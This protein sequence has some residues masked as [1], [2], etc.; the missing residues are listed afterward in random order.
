MKATS[1]N[2]QPING[3][4]E[5]HN[6]RTKELKYV[7]KD[8]SDKNE[9]F[10]IDTVKDRLATIKRT[11][12]ESTG[13]K[14]QKKATPIREGVVVIDKNTSMQQL[15]SFADKCEKR[16][17]I[18]AFQIHIHRDEGHHKSKG[19]WKEN[20]HAHIVYDW[21]DEKGKTVKLNRYDMIEMQTM[22]AES[23]EMKRGKSSD[24]KH[25]NAIQFKAQAEESRLEKITEESKR[26]FQANI[27]FTDDNK[28]LRATHSELK[29]INSH[30]IDSNKNLSADNEKLKEFNSRGSKS[31]YD[32]VVEVARAEQ[33]TRELEKEIKEVKESSRRRA[34]ATTNDVLS[35]IKAPYK[36]TD[37]LKIV[38]RRGGGLNQTM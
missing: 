18:K 2:I 17:G 25:L 16:F 29:N 7:R 1:I 19:E 26:I 30:L 12:R 9:S 13:Q 5:E 10:S 21:T 27:K 11:Y 3:G 23:L 6:L 20:L 24:R 36:L 38:S 37:D 8:L 15:K 22:L 34:I 28:T 35:K 32:L 14:M 4:S 33:R 31:N